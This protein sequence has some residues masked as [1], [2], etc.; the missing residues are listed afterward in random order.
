MP[1]LNGKTN[2]K[3][4]REEILAAGGFVLTMPDFDFEGYR[5]QILSYDVS[6]I[7]AGYL[8]PIKGIQGRTFNKD[9]EDLIKTARRGQRITIENIKV[10]SPD[11]EVRILNTPITIELKN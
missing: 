8:K 1:V 11:G 10:K 3:F 5:Y 2:D 9:V 6:T 4:T 7:V